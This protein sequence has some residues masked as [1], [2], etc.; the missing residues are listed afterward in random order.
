MHSK[1]DVKR[2]SVLSVCWRGYVM[3]AMD[4]CVSCVSLWVLNYTEGKQEKKKRNSSS[5]S[6]ERERERVWIQFTNWRRTVTK[7]Y[8][9]AVKEIPWNY[10]TTTQRYLEYIIKRRW[11]AKDHMRLALAKWTKFH[12]FFFSGAK[13]NGANK[14]QNDETNEEKGKDTN[15]IFG[16]ISSFAIVFESSS[17]P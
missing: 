9:T 4:V 5:S 17:V 3:Y 13:K 10:Y 8:A 2:S 1:I 6:T 14:R 16:N 15:Q 12:L 7:Y 11:V